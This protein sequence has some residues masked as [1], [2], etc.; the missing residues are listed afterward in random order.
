MPPLKP[1]EEG[2]PTIYV[3]VGVPCSGKSTWTA[4]HLSMVC[5]PTHVASTDAILERFALEDGTSY[6]EA[7]ATRFKEAESEFKAGI[8]AAARENMDIIVDRTNMFES[9]RRKVV[10]LVESST[11]RNYRRI[12]VNFLAPSDDVL[13]ARLLAREEAT[14]KVVP[15]SAVEQMRAS[16]SEPSPSDYH[17]IRTV[18]AF[19]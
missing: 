18:E 1:R 7:W 15:W 11:A 5:T 9:A 13:K 19:V 8:I 10:T 6:S 12:A 14:G 3:L 17:F 4:R 16:F 2:A